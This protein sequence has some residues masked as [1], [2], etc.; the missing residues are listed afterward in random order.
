MGRADRWVI[1]FGMWMGQRV[2]TMFKERI[3]ATNS[4]RW[5]KVRFEWFGDGCE[6]VVCFLLY[7]LS[8]D[9]VSTVALRLYNCEWSGNYRIVNRSAGGRKRSWHDLRYCLIISLEELRKSMKCPWIMCVLAE[10]RI[11]IF[12]PEISGRNI[13]TCFIKYLL[14]GTAYCIVECNHMF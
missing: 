13:T 2:W 7:V 5:F 10:I 4:E 3:I 6:I 11:C 14:S 12:F 8:G 9:V 1:L